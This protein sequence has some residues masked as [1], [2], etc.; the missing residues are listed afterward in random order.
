MYGS[1]DISTSGMIAQRTRMASIAAN[2]ANYDSLVDASGQ[3]NPY[4][5]RHVHLAPGDP[6]ARHA[7]GRRFG[8]HVAAVEI[9]RSPVQPRE[10]NPSHP[11]AY[12][13]GPFAGYVPTTGINPSVEWI[14]ALEASRAYEANV[15]AAEASKAM[16]TQALRLLA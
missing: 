2:I 5:R 13:D 12:K 10:Y 7:E 4:R 9:D 15:A 3:V 16:T 8:V 11:L 6:A 1:L 14:N